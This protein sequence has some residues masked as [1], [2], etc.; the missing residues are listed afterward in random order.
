MSKRI[1]EAERHYLNWRIESEMNNLTEMQVEHAFDREKPAVSIRFL[2]TAEMEWL[3]NIT[4]V[5]S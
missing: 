1:G 4:P 5:R 2:D 3:I